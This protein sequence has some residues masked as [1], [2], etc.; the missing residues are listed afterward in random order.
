MGKSSL[1]ALRSIKTFKYTVWGE[2][3]FFKTLNLVVYEITTVL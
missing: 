1:F 3:G 2:N